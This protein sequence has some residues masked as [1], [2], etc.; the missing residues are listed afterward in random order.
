MLF[1]IFGFIQLAFLGLIAYYLTELKRLNCEC[2]LQPPYKVL[3][4]TIWFLIGIRVILLAAQIL[5]KTPSQSQLFPMAVLL[6]FIT[7]AFYGTSI[8]FI[9]RLYTTH[10]ACSPQ[11]L[12]LVYLIYS[13]LKVAWLI[14]AYIFLASIYMYARRRH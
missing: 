10:C 13:I 4:A 7:L 8:Y 2:A 9:T 3:Y 1:P 6:G 5:N 11:M 12:Q 14:F